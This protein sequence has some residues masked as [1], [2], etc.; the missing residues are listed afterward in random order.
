MV[1][2]GLAD[3]MILSGDL[4]EVRDRDLQVSGGRV[5]GKGNSRCKSLLG[6]PQTQQRGGI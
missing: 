1:R 3:V 2:K 6:M 4:R 5:L